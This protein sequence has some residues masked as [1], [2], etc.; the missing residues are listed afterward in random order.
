MT[1]Q[2]AKDALVESFM[3]QRKPRLIMDFY[4]TL[5]LGLSRSHAYQYLSDIYYLEP[6]SVQR[7]VREFEISQE[8]I[9]G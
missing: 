8:E 5:A 1:P 4:K 3:S 2:Q 6:R 9:E 7:I